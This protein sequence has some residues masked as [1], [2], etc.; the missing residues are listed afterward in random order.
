MTAIIIG[1]L[2]GYAFAC[3][4]QEQRELK[5]QRRREFRL[6]VAI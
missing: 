2:V 5:A 1:A 3:C 6:G 4:L